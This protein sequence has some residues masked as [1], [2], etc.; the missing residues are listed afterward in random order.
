[1]SD[2]LISC[3]FTG[4][5]PSKLW[6]KYEYN[7]A[8]CAKLK[9]NLKSAVISAVNSGVSR[10]YT[11]M[12]PGVDLWAAE[13]VLELQRDFPRLGLFAILPFLEQS[14]A[15]SSEYKLL[16]DSVLRRC[17]GVEIVSVKTDAHAF[18]KRNV[19]LVELA[20]CVI[21]VYD[22]KY[23]RSGTGQTVRMAERAVQF[24]SLEKIIFVDIPKG[25][26]YYGL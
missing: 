8:A 15:F 4:H 16:Y 1:M 7:P 20:D 9:H 13:I 18:K 12:A 10:F 17:S 6:P 26:Q 25:D 21:A 14:D 11:G 22:K 19:R 3:S 23:A 2:N 5:R 24:G